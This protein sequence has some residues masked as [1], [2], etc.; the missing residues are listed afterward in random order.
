MHGNRS[1]GKSNNYLLGF[2]AS[3]ALLIGL[4]VLLLGDPQKW[5]AG[6]RS[7]EPLVVYCAAGIRLPVE[8]AAREYELAYG[9]PV[10][11]QFGGSQT[12]LAGIEVTRR[13]DLYIPADDSFLEIARQKDLIHDVFPLARMGIV[14]AV[15]RGN[16]MAI[17]SLDDLLRR[18]IRLVQGN[19]DAAAVGTM[20]RAI[21]QKTGQWE[22]LSGNTATFKMTV[23]EVA[24]D[25]LLGAADAGIVWDSTVKQTPGLEAIPLAPLQQVQAHVSAAI[26]R[27]STQPTSTRRFAQYLA[28]RDRGLPLFAQHGFTPVQ[29][30]PWSEA[31]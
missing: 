20:T 31:P 5:F 25:V 7:T 12:L 19:P 29:G 27:Q 26:L 11:L 22:A 3:V 6:E 17:H 13:G 15:R 9:V 8:A 14:A 30:E 10:Q 16:P 4:V 2:L 1:R 21:L 23:N 24:N 28:A 18:D